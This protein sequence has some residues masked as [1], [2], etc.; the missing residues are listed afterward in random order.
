[1]LVFLCLKFLFFLIT[2][3]HPL[4][5]LL[6]MINNKQVSL[7]LQQLQA[8]Y[9]QAFKRNYLFYSQIKTKGMLDE[10]KELIPWILAAMIFVSIS[11]SLSLFIEQRFP[12]FDTFQAS[13]IAVLAI[14]L[15]FMLIV[16]IIIKQIKHSS[17]HLYQQLSNSPLKIAVVILLQAVNFAFI[18]SFLLQA[19]LFFL[20]ISFGFVR[21]Y[22]ENMFREHTK[23]TD[24]YNLQQIR[25]VCFWSY[26]Q[27]VKLKVR[28]SLTPKKST[29]YA[30][31]KKQLAQISE[32]HVQLIQY[33]NE[34]CRTYKFV[35]LDAYMDSLM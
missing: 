25:R 21:F 29:E 33:E 4:P 18:Q 16:P 10:L 3:H 15:F 30:V 11:I 20:A 22:K 6:N 27:A 2:M 12:R 31:F 7:Y 9:P 14:M 23:D 26:K 35:D 1:M 8:E 19:V 13:A 17:V 24:Y 28:L 5:D 34:L 32:L